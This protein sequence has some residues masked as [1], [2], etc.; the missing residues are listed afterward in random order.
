MIH[1]LPAGELPLP[2]GVRARIVNNGNG[3]EMHILEAGYQDPRR[4][5]VLL[6]HGFPELAYSWRNVLPV[7]AAAGYHAVAPD[8]RG[9][10]NTSGWYDHDD[11]DDTVRSCRLFNLM[12]DCL[13]LVM[14]LGRSSLAAI[15]GHDFGSF[16]A[17]VC[18]LIRP[19]V[20]RSVV[21]MSAPF[22]GL[23]KAQAAADTIHEELARLNPPRKHY[24]WYFSGPEAAADMLHCP[25]GVHDFLRAYF[26]H[27]SADW[28][29]NRPFPLASWSASELAKMPSYYI[30]ESDQDMPTTV[31]EQMPSAQQIAACA[32]LPD[33]QLRVYSEAFARNGFQQPLNWYRCMTSA[34]YNAELLAYAGRSIEVP[35]C[36]I[37]GENDWGSYQKPGA[38]EAMQGDA[39]THLLGVH[40]V[41]GAGHWV[42]QEQAQAVNRLLLDFLHQAGAEK[43]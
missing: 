9:Y 16:V 14:A 29:R 24:Q 2:E 3:L 10:G 8:Q 25:Q 42:Q 23:P 38:L 43:H 20:F 32:W 19:D 27:K 28:P 13:G 1:D 21:L 18:A 35:A 15:V 7:L 41:A 12:L 4:P 11:G 6:L 30:M 37:A 17:A 26:H 22:G 40:L 34:A 33:S 36:Y 31:A 5:C 39:C